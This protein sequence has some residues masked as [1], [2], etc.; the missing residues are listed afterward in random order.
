MAA[1]D[2]EIS[3][4]SEDAEDFA[5]NSTAGELLPSN[6]ANGSSDSGSNREDESELGKVPF[7]RRRVEW[8]TVEMWDREVLEDGH[9]RDCILNKCAAIYE[10][11]W[12]FFRCW[13]EK[14]THES[15]L[16]G[17][18]EQEA[19]QGQNLRGDLLVLNKIIFLIP[20]LCARLTNCNGFEQV[21]V[22]DCPLSS[23]YNCNR[24]AKLRVSWGPNKLLCKRRTCIL[25]RVMQSTIGNS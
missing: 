15:R 14:E 8:E 12:P 9:I 10:R 17:A 24:L 19:R 22:Y 1:S 11:S 5:E 25:Q 18:T 7:R 16:L 3:T 4:E 23:K 13:S 20:F 6:V 21:F 2:C